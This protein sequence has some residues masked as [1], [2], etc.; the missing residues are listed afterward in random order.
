[1]N[2]EDSKLKRVVII[3]GGFGG[4]TLAK[5]LDES[6]FQ[7]I[8]IDKNNYHTFQPLLYQVATGGLEPD[9]IA[10]PIR[11]IFSRKKNFYFRMA[12]VIKIN[13]EQMQV[14]TSSGTVSYDYLVIATGSITNFFGN[15]EIELNSMSMKNVVEA[16]DLRSL[17]LQNFEKLLIETNILNRAKYL[18]IVIVGG[19]PT[20][21]EI[22][23]ALAE[24]KK[25]VLPRDYPGNNFSSLQIHIIEAVD[26]L[27]ANMSLQSSQKA[28]QFLIEMDVK[29]MTNTRV[30][31]CRDE[32]VFLSDASI[33]DSTIVIWAAGVK[34]NT[35]EGF[36]ESNY[37]K[38]NRYKVDMYNQLIGYE[39]VFVIGDA[40]SINDGEKAYNHP[41]LAPVAMQQAKTL[42][43]NLNSSNQR[44]WKQ[45][46]YRDLG[47]MATIGRNKAVVDFH[48]LKFQGLIAWF[49]WMFVHLMSIVGFRNRLIVLINWMWSYISYDR[50]ILLII[51]PFKRKTG[52]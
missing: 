8:M 2:I 16:L 41:M 43:H 32:K 48:K 17:C 35:I 31:S 47:S 52:Y 19:G 25:H 26:K 13:T 37:A 42:A 1:M 46:R 28:E 51:R 22:A 20:G 14:E 29:I 50:A 9:S 6:K 39:N 21:V 7:V 36:S 18:N 27:L 12:E 11:K 34:G 44:S 24:L 3:G 40:A 15:K 45:F 49:V 33:I 30:E 10:Y 23:G 4:I 38:G 5:K